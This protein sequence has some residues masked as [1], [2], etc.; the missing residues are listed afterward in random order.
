[1]SASVSA[2]VL[3]VGSR[4]FLN[5]RHRMHSTESTVLPMEERME[6]SMELRMEERIETRM[7]S[8]MEERMEQKDGITDGRKDGRKDGIRTE[9]KGWN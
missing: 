3:R 5:T 8:R 6:E 9:K 4:S 7:E 1:M 2:S